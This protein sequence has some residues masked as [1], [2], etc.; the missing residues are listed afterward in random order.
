MTWTA[1]L[2]RDGQTTAVCFRHSPDADDALKNISAI[3]RC[4]GYK[5][6]GI[7]KGDQTQTFYG[8]NFEDNSIV[9]PL[10]DVVA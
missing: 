6:L 8:I 4:D 10:D 3:V 7:A 2:E 9:T 5:V 1:I